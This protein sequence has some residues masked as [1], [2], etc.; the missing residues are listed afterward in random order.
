MLLHS[1][2]LSVTGW[3]PVV[4]TGWKAVLRRVDRRSG[5]WFGA[6]LAAVSI[7][8]LPGGA[9]LAGSKP[10][11]APLQEYEFGMVFQA[12]GGAFKNVT[13]TVTVPADWP[14]Q[15]RVQSVKEDLPPG[16][17]VSYKAMA[18]VGR[19][20]TVRIPSLPPG[21]EVRAVVTFE[22]ER[23]DGP[24]LPPETQSFQVPKRDPKTAVHLAPSPAHR[25]RSSRGP[26]GGRSS[27]G[28]PPRRWE[29]AKAIHEWVARTIKPSG[30]LDN[31]QTTM[32]TLSRRLGACAEMNSLAVAMLRC[33]GIPARLVRV[34]K[35]CYYEFF[36]LDGEGQGH[37]LSADATLP[38][39]LTASGALARN[40]PAEGRQRAHHRSG[41]Q[42][43]HPGPLPGRD[44][45]RHAVG[46][47]GP[48][49]PAD[50]SGDSGQTGQGEE[51]GVGLRS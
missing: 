16:A 48:A 7:W 44:G 3:K 5:E 35:H 23:L 17:T 28:R 24:A 19:Q 10:K 8:L 40:D 27:R 36:L 13:G 37:W 12:Q 20:M 25:V 34:P 30:E 47:R 42:E 45:H 4:L 15:Q 18:G 51:W 1:S 43:A 33:Q 26:T 41:H 49:I 46:G 31:V 50:Q 38:A 6:L 29:K 22:V 11:A 21:R 9:A 32:Q 39:A 2:A 14:D